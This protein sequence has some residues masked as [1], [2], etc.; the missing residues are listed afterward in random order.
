MKSNID[1]NKATAD[2]FVNELYIAS[3]KLLVEWEKAGL[4]KDRNNIDAMAGKLD[5]I[6]ESNSF[7]KFVAQHKLEWEKLTQKQMEA[8]LNMVGQFGMGGLIGGGLL[9]KQGHNPVKGY[10]DYK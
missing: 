7:K 1:L 9:K 8:I 2:N 6:K 10:S 4:I 3:E 5:A